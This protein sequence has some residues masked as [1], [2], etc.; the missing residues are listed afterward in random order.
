M[1]GF[2]SCSYFVF[3]KVYFLWY[4]KAE[5]KS[6]CAIPQK[7]KQQTNLQVFYG[8]VL[9]IAS[10]PPSIQHTLPPW[11]VADLPEWY[12]FLD[13]PNLFSFLGLWPCWTVHPDIMWQFSSVIQANSAANLLSW[14][15][16]SDYPSLSILYCSNLSF[17]PSLTPPTTASFAV[18]FT[19][20]SP[21]ALTLLTSLDLGKPENHLSFLND[22]KRLDLCLP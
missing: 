18:S 9:I 16:H 19:E 3:L 5:Q 1:K 13:M 2:F 21:F 4:R 7:S 6:D 15:T 17:A 12:L 22:P 10:M 20:W 11:C 14:Q 8:K